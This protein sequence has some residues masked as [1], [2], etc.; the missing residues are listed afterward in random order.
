MQ[1]VYTTAP[2]GFTENKFLSIN[3]STEL[4]MY[5]AQPLQ[6]QDVRQGHFL[7]RVQLV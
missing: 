7:N 3:M 1:L 6:E 4:S 2:A 5:F